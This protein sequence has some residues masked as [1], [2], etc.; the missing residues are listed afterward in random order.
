MKKLFLT[1]ALMTA[2]LSTYAQGNMTFDLG[3]KGGIN[4]TK[5]TTENP[6]ITGYTFDDFKSDSKMGYNL[7]LFA[8]LGGERIYLQPELLYCIRKGETVFNSS[9]GGAS[10][11]KLNLKT[12]Q[13]PVLL[14]F[15]LIDL[16]LVSIHAFT[17]PAMSFI[18]SSSNV[19][20]NLPNFD[21]NNFKNNIWDWQLGAGIDM[22]PL[23]FDIRY[24][25]GL[26]K[27]SDGNFSP[28][29]I[30]FVNKGNVLTFSL[31]LKFM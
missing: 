13:V 18:L 4:S 10:I 28:S 8:R 22:G 26:T 11:Q 2:L 25:W 24:E 21:P 15:N 5:V 20:S 27:Y 17:G 19:E 16:R 12:I 6:S 14:G 30:G 7:G 23:V 3:V 31:G 29:N 9:T 1:F